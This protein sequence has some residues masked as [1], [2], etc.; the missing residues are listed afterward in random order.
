MKTIYE[1]L[2]LFITACRFGKWDCGYEEKPMIGF[3]SGYYDDF[4]YN[5]HIYK[6]WIGVTY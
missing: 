4:N 2:S 5:L 6:F 1:N 3:Y